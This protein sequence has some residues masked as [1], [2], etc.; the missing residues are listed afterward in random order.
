[1]VLIDRDGEIYRFLDHADLEEGHVVE[2]IEGL[3]ARR[4]GL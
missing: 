4:S 1:M 2:A 3:L